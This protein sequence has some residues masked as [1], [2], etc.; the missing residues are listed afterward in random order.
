MIFNRPELTGRVFDAIAAVQ[1]TRLLVVADGPRP[2]CP[3]D[4]RLCAQA[5][6]V[7]DRVDWPCEVSTCYADVN[8]GC[9]LRISSGLDWVFGQVPE[10]IVLEDDC[11]P[12]PDFFRFCDELLDRYRDE[13]RI[14]MVSGCNVLGP[15]ASLRYSYYFSRCYHIWGW[16][17][18][19][20]AWK[21]YDV[22]MRRWPELRAD[23]WLESYVDDPNVVRILRILFDETHAGRMPTWDF[24][25]VFA[26]WA[27]SALSV[28]PAANLVTNIGYG[29]LATHERDGDSPLASLPTGRLAF[30][31][32]HA[33]EIAVLE[34]ADAAEWRFVYPDFFA[35]APRL[36]SDRFRDALRS[37]RAALGNRSA[38]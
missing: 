23:G 25:W 36:R 14:Q 21:S 33:P 35:T 18:W 4:E 29:E 17:T 37:V 10:A 1:P 16:A 2:S 8:L 26:G 5:R 22:Q 30:P 9:K 31:L 34:E 3:D 13:P 32:T 28:T 15:Q 11:V 20:R 7:I 24:Q 38:A 27:A 12:E 19:A 6:A